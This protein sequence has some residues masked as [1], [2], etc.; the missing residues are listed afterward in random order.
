MLCLCLVA[1]S[2]LSLCSP[3]DCSLP[4][5]SLHGYSPGKNIGVDCHA[6]LH[7][8]FPTQ[9]LN[10]CIQH[11][12]WIIYQLSHQG[13]SRIL[14]CVAYPFSSGSSQPKIELGSLSCIAGRFFTSWITREALLSY[15]K[16][17]KPIKEKK[18][19]FIKIKNF[20]SSRNTIKGMK[21][22]TTE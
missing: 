15:Y 12:R 14:E 8:I 13:N 9:G 22:Q 17:S 5:S 2:C 1:Q 11:C 16:K 19:D 20:C 3:M 6:L 4:G 18:M 21:R 10:P 7:G